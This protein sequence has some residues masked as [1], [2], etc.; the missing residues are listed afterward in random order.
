MS[1]F[2]FLADN[3]VGVGEFPWCSVRQ[4]EQ[5][6]EISLTGW[7]QL[8]NNVFPPILPFPVKIQQDEISILNFYTPNAKPPTFIKVTMLKLE[9]YI[10]RERF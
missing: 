5:H 8:F 7:T 4:Q 9:S 2:L 1:V 3:K 6:Q 10:N